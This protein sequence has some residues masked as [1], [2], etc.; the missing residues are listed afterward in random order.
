MKSPSCL[1]ENARVVLPGEVLENGS[2]LIEDGHIS[3]VGPMA[4][5]ADSV[6]MHLETIDARGAYLL[7][8]L[9]DMHTD[10]LDKEITP[11]PAADFP[12]EVAVQEL[13]RKLVG[14]G[15]TTV[16]HSLHFGYHEAQ[17]GSRSRYGRDEVVQGVLDMQRHTLA[18]TKVHARFE[19]S[20]QLPEAYALVE[21]LL[22]EGAFQLISFMD[23]TPGQGQYTRERFLAQRQREGMSLEQ[24]EAE[25]RRCQDRHP[26]PD[27]QLAAM[28][29]LAR[30]LAVP[31][32][33]H[34]DD[35]AE[36]VRRMHELGVTI[37]EFPINLEA[38]R[39]A[40]E[41]GQHVLAGAANVLRGGSLTGNLHVAD[42]MRD[43]AVDG[44]CSDYY[45]PAMLHAAFKLWHEGVLSLP[46]AIAAVSR[47][48]AE[49][50]QIADQVG[51]IEPGLLAD[52]VLVGLRGQV[53]FVQATFVQGE[54]VH[55]A[56]RRQ[57]RPERTPM[58]A[59]IAAL[60]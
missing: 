8:G 10:T 39:M 60:A 27:A 18:R 40:R 50:V 15:V 6:P 32:A 38:A 5:V 41:L 54:Q 48:P 17:W 55:A 47:V 20:G 43:G 51:S 12:I 23:H 42:A 37:C 45:P 7:P 21:R 29:E 49:A 58:P 26:V 11:R 30:A 53:P 4:E 44:L 52:L 24:A 13:D 19:V 59:A 46:R 28:A 22:R 25:L 14:C 35:S 1:I 34:D 57:R 56:G 3:A 33:S 31:V 2:V 9:I 36:K 16:F